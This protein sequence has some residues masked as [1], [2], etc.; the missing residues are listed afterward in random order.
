MNK[1]ESLLKVFPEL[2]TMSHY[3]ET[4]IYILPHNHGSLYFKTK[5]K[6][7]KGREEFDLLKETLNESIQLST[8]NKK[9]YLVR[10]T[11][12]S[13]HEEQTSEEELSE[14]ELSDEE[15]SEEELSERADS[16]SEDSD[17]ED[18]DSEEQ[19]SKENRSQ[20]VASEERN[21][22]QESSE[23]NPNPEQSH[24]GQSWT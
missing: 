21:S 19:T 4:I 22:D 17:S 6:Q 1:T 5:P 13:S 3:C 18:S 10:S 2:L 16:D 11:Y 24:F 7:L 12:R 9:M 14:E 15:L 8:F 23:A 20:R